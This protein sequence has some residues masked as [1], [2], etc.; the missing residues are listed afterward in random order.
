MVLPKTRLVVDATRRGPPLVI[1][2]AIRTLNWVIRILTQV[3][4]P[5]TTVSIVSCTSLTLPSNLP[6]LPGD[7]DVGV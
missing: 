2:K 3:I 1:S 7:L 6:V 4:S 5:S